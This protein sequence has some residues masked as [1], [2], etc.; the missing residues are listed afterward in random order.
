VP[1]IPP[2]VQSPW[3]SPTR[4]EKVCELT[5]LIARLEPLRAR[6]QSVVLSQGCFDLVHVGHVRHFR[7]ARR[8][9][10]LLVVGIT[11]DQYVTKGPDRPLFPLAQR[12]EFVAEL[13]TVDFVVAS[14]TATAIP[15]LRQLR[16][17]VYI[18]GAEYE[19]QRS[20]DPRFVE[21][22]RIVAGYGGTVA[23]SHD[24]LVSS[25]TRLQRWL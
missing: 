14:M 19:T 17:D 25:S 20:D 23:F 6:G 18:R 13:E 21:E 22:Q 9:G 3:A 12:M 24:E 10:H 4:P 16:P 15:L 2:P 8:M 1:F 11:E 5:D 7:E